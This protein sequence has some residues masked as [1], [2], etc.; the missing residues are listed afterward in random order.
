MQPAGIEPKGLDR[1]RGQRAT[2]RLRMH[3]ERLQRPPQPIVVEQRR[4]D[5]EQL[6]HRRAGRPPGHVIQRRGR[7][8][9]RRD[10]TGHDLTDRQHR[11]RAARQAAIHDTDQ[12]EHP[13]EVPGQQKR[14]HLPPRPRHRRIQPG[15][16]PGER[17]ELPGLFQRLLPPQ[18]CHNTMPHPAVLIAIPID[19]L[20][21][22]VRAL[23]APDC[24]LL[25]EHVATTLPASPDGKT[26]SIN[27]KLPQQQRNPPRP[28]RQQPNTHRRSQPRLP[29]HKRGKRG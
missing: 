8:Q 18:I 13:D 14:P 27:T 1:P 2:D 5:P 26:N 7:A 11:A 25:D 12:I 15:E 29:T 10:Q 9:P 23:T 6:V 24:G 16:R 3:R 22:R 4:R 19:Q 20:Q 17:L 28:Q 21:V